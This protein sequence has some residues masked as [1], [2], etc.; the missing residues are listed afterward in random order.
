[1]LLASMCFQAMYPSENLEMLYVKNILK[2]T[3]WSNHIKILMVFINTIITLDG[4]RFQ[5][6]LNRVFNHFLK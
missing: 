5:P 4:E 1:M 2:V 3:K 6:T